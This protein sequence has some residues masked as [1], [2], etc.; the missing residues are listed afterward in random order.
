MAIV[1]RGMNARELGAWTQAMI[2]SGDRLDLS[3]V[4]GLKVDKHSTGGV[5]DKVTLC[6]APLVAACGVPVPMLVGRALGHTG[7]TADKLEAI[8]GFRTVLSPRAFTRVL[9]KAGFVIAGQTREL[10]P[11]DKRLYALR[12][13]TATVESI[14]LIAASILSKKVAGGAEALVLDVKVGSGAFLPRRSDARRLARTLVSLGRQLGLRTVAL[15]TAMDEPLGRQ[16]GCALEVREAVDVLQGRGPEDTVAVTRRLG[17]EMLVL[18]G[19]VRTIDEGAARI[20]A[21]VASG[22]GFERFLLG[23]RMQGGDARTLERLDLL[24]RAR[25]RAV[26]RAPSTGFLQAVDAR[27]VGVAATLLG[28]GRLRPGDAVDPA[29]GITLHHKR[30]DP[31]SLGDALCTV[32]Y[33]DRSRWNAARADLARAFRIGAL[34]G[35][36]SSHRLLQHRWILE[37]IA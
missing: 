30:G 4:P 25:H 31:V 2:A 6:L 13:I 8:P 11:A 19:A 3:A 28:A 33:N 34:R 29:V 26:L 17:A 7:G 35:R 12:D 27:A 10:V 15:L 32:S 23:V 21:A 14:P 22:A 24:P 36:L 16:V 1:F 20:D 5:G 37:R 18:G 9:G